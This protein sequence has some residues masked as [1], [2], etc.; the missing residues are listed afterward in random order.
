MMMM[1]MVVVFVASFAWLSKRSIERGRIV[2]EETRPWEKVANRS[3]VGDGAEW[4]ERPSG[5]IFY[6][7]KRKK[8]NRNK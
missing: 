2:E 3:C 4:I 1:M 6:L 8:T 7:D 5:R